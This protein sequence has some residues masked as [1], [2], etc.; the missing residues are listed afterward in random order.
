MERRTPVNV[1]MGCLGGWKE[2]IDGWMGWE[3][4]LYRWKNGWTE[5]ELLRPLPPPPFQQ[6]SSPCRTRR[7][8]ACG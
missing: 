8:R 5:F 4:W 3:G 7:N 6:I 2:C 1:C